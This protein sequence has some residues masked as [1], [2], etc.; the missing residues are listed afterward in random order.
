MTQADNIKALF[1]GGYVL[2]ALE[3]AK[4]QCIGFEYIGNYPD[5]FQ[6]TLYIFADNSE[7]K[8]EA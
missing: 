1:D 8:P 2:Q 6:V 3:L 4:A 7:F 5:N